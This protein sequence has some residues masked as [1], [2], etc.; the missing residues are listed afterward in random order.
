MKRARFRIERAMRRIV[1]RDADLARS[2]RPAL[3]RREGVRSESGRTCARTP[4][5]PLSAHTFRRAL[6][7]G[8]AILSVNCVLLTGIR[9]DPGRRLTPV[10]ISFTRFEQLVNT[11]RQ[12]RRRFE[13]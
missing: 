7:F 1:R 8:A 13:E 2:C 11:P 6:R 9:W 10:A 3:R 12:A 5:T 4:R